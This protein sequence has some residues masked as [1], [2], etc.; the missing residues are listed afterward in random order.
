MNVGLRV[1]VEEK[2]CVLT[3]RI[4]IDVNDSNRS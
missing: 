4:V 3:I 2:P 1:M